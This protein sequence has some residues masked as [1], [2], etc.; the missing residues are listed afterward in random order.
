MTSLLLLL[1]GK[2]FQ[3]TIC[4]FTDVQPVVL[5]KLYHTFYC[6]AFM[7]I[8]IAIK[9]F[10]LFTCVLQAIIIEEHISHIVHYQLMIL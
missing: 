5:L 7:I 6:C 8:C 9:G 1:E 10:K 3:I 4:A 2:T